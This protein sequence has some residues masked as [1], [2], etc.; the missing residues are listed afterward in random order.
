MI[1]TSHHGIRRDCLADHK[2]AILLFQTQVDPSHHS[3]PQSSPLTQT[4]DPQ[5]T[6]LLPQRIQCDWPLQPTILPTS[7]LPLCNHPQ[8]CHHRVP[9]PLHEDHRSKLASNPVPPPTSHLLVLKPTLTALSHAIKTVGTHQTLPKLHQ[10]SLPNRHPPP[11]LAHLPHPQMQTTPHAPHPSRHPHS[12]P[13]SRRRTIGGESRSEIG[14]KS[15]KEG[16]YE[17]KESRGGGEGGKSY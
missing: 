12:P 3:P 1:L 6:K 8:R 5:T 4:Q 7:Q 10:G 2:S 17:G 16:S 13:R 15:K 9:L 11:L 14:A